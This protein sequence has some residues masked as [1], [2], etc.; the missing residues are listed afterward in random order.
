MERESREGDPDEV[1]RRDRERRRALF[2]YEL[3]EARELRRRI[4]P[5]RTR[6]ERIR[7]ALRKRTFRTM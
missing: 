7:A 4:A 2:L 6:R 5:K 3:A 1:E